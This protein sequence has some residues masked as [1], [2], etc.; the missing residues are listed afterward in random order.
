L[1]I[2]ECEVTENGNFEDIEAVKDEEMGNRVT[3]DEAK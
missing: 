2:T 3:S 1:N